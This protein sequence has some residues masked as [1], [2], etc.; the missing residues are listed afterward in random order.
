MRL[1]KC[2]SVDLFITMSFHKILA[3]SMQCTMHNQLDSISV[4]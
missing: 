3:R 2:L 1:S 4:Q